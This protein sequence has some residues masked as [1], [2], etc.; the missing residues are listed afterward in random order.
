[1]IELNFLRIIVLIMG[2]VSALYVVLVVDDDA[3]DS[4][5]WRLIVVVAS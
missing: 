1:M 4:E 2:L 3:L 5:A